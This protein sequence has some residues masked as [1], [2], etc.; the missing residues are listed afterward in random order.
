MIKS[1][2]GKVIQFKSALVGDLLQD[3]DGHI[4]RVCEHINFPNYEIKN[5]AVA[6][7]YT[8]SKKNM[9]TDTWLESGERVPFYFHPEWH[10]WRVRSNGKRYTVIGESPSSL[11][12]LL[13]RETYCQLTRMGIHFIEDLNHHIQAFGFEDI[14]RLNR[15]GKKRRAMITNDLLDA[16]FELKIA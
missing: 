12:P 7:L 4:F 5:F 13:P 3:K 1:R 10:D 15:I 2:V 11:E 8:Y 14:L 6:V 9:N 16:G